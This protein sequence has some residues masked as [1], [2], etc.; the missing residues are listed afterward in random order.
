MT[1]ELKRPLEVFLSPSIIF[2]MKKFQ[3]GKWIQSPYLQSFWPHLLFFWL[4]C[5]VIP[6]HRILEV[7]NPTFV[8]ADSRD[9]WHRLFVLLYMQSWL[10]LSYSFCRV[11]RESQAQLQ[12]WNKWQ[13]LFLSGYS[14]LLIYHIL[15][16]KGMNQNWFFKKYNDLH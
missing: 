16:V 1:S 10:V 9:N 11:Y 5:N 6:P 14:C 4:D 8:L 13:S 2:K 3:S 12:W 7:V 15:H